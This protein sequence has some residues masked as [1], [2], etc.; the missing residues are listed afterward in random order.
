MIQMQ[1]NKPVCTENILHITSGEMTANALRE[2]LPQEEILPFNE[3]MCEGEVHIEIFTDEFYRLRAAAYGVELE[4]YLQKSP[5]SFMQNR[6]KD[7]PVLYLYFDYDMFCTVN[8]ITLL[9]F[10]EQSGYSGRIK[11]HLLEADGSVAILDTWPVLLGIYEKCYCRVLLKR[12]RFITGNELFDKGIELYIEYK[13]RNNRIIR[14]IK[15][16]S[17]EEQKHLVRDLV[18]KF[19]DYGLT[20][21]AAARFITA[22]RDEKR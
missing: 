7:Y 18:L 4:D 21:I 6:L 19:A 14:Y 10:L 15:A 3:A 17:M 22:C 12:Q 5:G 13:K 2:L 20:D 1:N 16:H 11:F 8:I 9:A